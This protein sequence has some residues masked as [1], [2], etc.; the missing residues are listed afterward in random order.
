MFLLLILAAI[1]DKYITQTGSDIMGGGSSYLKF[2]PG[3]TPDHQGKPVS[4]EYYNHSILIAYHEAGRYIMEKP[5]QHY[6]TIGPNNQLIK[7]NKD[8]EDDPLKIKAQRM[9]VI[10]VYCD[11]MEMSFPEG[12]EPDKII[13]KREV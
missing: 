10:L 2:A 3:F 4:E 12:F 7:W 1:S 5:K 11:E 9:N 6:C 13:A 8:S